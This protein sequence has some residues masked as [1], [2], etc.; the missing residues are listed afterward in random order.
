MCQASGG[1]DTLAFWHL[2]TSLFLSRCCRKYPRYN[3]TN[4]PHK[5]ENAA[6]DKTEVFHQIFLVYL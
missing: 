1:V 2:D 5:M 6:T 3:N 4:A